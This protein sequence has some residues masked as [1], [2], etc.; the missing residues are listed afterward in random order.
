MTNTYYIAITTTKGGFSDFFKAETKEQA[1]EKA[2]EKV[3]AWNFGKVEK[4]FI[5]TTK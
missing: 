4:I 1:I 2:T 5:K 3:K